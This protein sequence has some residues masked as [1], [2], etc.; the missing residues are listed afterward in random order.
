[1]STNIIAKDITATWIPYV[2]FSDANGTRQVECTTPPFL[3]GLHQ[4]EVFGFEIDKPNIT[5]SFSRDLRAV[6]HWNFTLLATCPQGEYKCN[7]YKAFPFNLTLDC[8]K[9]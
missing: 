5:E 7:A 4:E 1:M 3:K 9:P 8:R 2:D 6:G